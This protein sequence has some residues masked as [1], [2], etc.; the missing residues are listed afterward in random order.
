MRIPEKEQNWYE[1]SAESGAVLGVRAADEDSALLKADYALQDK[2]NLVWQLPANLA[3][4]ALKMNH[5][6]SLNNE[7]NYI[8]A[9]GK[10]VKPI[11]LATL[12]LS[13]VIKE[14]EVST[15]QECEGQIEI[16]FQAAIIEE[17]I[18]A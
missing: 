10:S 13:T 6:D 3:G 11:F 15:A 14:T 2:D 1:V 18:A 12:A 4:F 17:S 9:A 16:P 7:M 5:N 8:R